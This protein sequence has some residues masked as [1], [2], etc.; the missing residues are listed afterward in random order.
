MKNY[1]FALAILLAILSAGRLKAETY[2]I[3]PENVITGDVHIKAG[4]Y[5]QKNILIKNG[6]L[7]IEGTYTSF[8]VVEG[9]SVTVKG[10]APGG[11]ISYGG[12]VN[13][14]GYAGKISSYKGLVAISGRVKSINAIETEV[15]LSSSSKVQGKVNIMSSHVIIRPGAV[16]NAQKQ[17]IE[18]KRPP[19]EYFPAYRIHKVTENTE[20]VPGFAAGIGLLLLVPVLFIRRSVEGGSIILR[21][22]FWKSAGAGILICGAIALISI[23]G[24]EYSVLFP[25]ALPAFCAGLAAL[26]IGC[27]AFCRMLGDKIFSALGKARPEPMLAVASGYIAIMAIGGV[28]SVFL[29]V[30]HWYYPNPAPDTIHSILGIISLII[31]CMLISAGIIGTGA[32][33]RLTPSLIKHE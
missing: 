5:L 9:G 19:A 32:L 27:S 3:D 8:C 11:I 12:P 26:V 29:I 30:A 18:H 21:E 33:G 15:I 23:T 16:I 7:L 10:E 20:T 25:F 24:A 17:I 14:S 28:I 6:N 2:Y 22:S 1:K 4:E 31:S 13:V